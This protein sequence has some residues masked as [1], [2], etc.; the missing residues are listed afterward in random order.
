MLAGDKWG[1]AY[2]CDLKVERVHDDKG[3]G[4]KMCLQIFCAHLPRML[5]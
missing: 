4:A 5:S 2:S 1:S 3:C